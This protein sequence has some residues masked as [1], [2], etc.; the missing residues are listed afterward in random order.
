MKEQDFFKQLHK[1]LDAAP[2]LK[3]E[4]LNAPISSVA[5]DLSVSSVSSSLSGAAS[6]SSANEPN[7]TVSSF[8]PREKRNRR[9]GKAAAFVSV[10]AAVALVSASA[11]ALFQGGGEEIYRYAYIDI[12][13]S[14]AFVLDKNCKVEK[15]LSCNAD[16]DALLSDS[17]FVKDMV[18]TKFEKAAVMIAER[19][20]QNGYFEFGEAGDPDNYNEIDVL[21]QGNVSLPETTLKS[22]KEGLVEYFCS[23]GLYVYVNM[24]ETARET[25]EAKA[26]VQAFR[27]RAQGY[28]DWLRETGEDAKLDGAIEE[29]IFDY[30][31]DLLSDSLKKYDLIAEIDD[32]NEQIESDPDNIFSLGYWTVNRELNENVR[33]LCVQTEKKLNLL[34]ALFDVGKDLLSY[35]AAAAAVKA[36]AG[37]ADV[38]ALRA[39]AKDG[40]T[41]EE[42]KNGEVFSA[43]YFSFV[44]N[45]VFKSVLTGLID[46]GKAAEFAEQ[47]GSLVCERAEELVNRYSSI[48]SSPVDVVDEG[49][50]AAFL[51]RIGKEN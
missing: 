41:A 33:E 49:E 34:N 13:P 38:E 3:S 9:R 39:L 22:V 24:T 31:S 40:L 29:C 30:A 35:K 20:A 28:I 8:K 14:V 21:M 23:S 10:A 19:A 47:I 25:S 4:V 26:T 7:K 18:G 12:N 36:T 43:G 11:F 15:V 46:G 44:S 50:Y 42:F 27:N 1:E 37:L 51:K 45:E 48:L 16:A 6:V 32:L 2:A 17:A 5:S